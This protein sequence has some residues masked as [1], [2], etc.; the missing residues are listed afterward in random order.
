[1][2]KKHINEFMRSYNGK[3]AGNGM[4]EDRYDEEAWGGGRLINRSS[5]WKDKKDIEETEVKK[6]KLSKEELEELE[7]RLKDA[8]KWL[9]KRSFKDSKQY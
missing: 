7:R 5:W 9:S 2:A 1:M 8:S 4:L 3:I 6:Y